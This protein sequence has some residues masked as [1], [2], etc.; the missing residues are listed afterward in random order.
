M[1][2]I[3]EKL[4][5]LLGTKAAIRQ[6]IRDK[7]VEVTD[8]DSFR[9]YADKIAS[10]EG[11]SLVVSRE[12]P[13][14]IFFDYD[15]SVAYSYTSEEALT[16]TSM[17]DQPQH[18]GL[19]R[20]G[21]NK[22]YEKMI[23]EVSE[24]GFCAVEPLYVTN[25]GH[26]RLFISIDALGRQ[27]YPLYI[28]A[29]VAGSVS[30]DWGDGS[31]E[32][33]F[34]DLTT[35][36]TYHFYA[37]E[38]D[39]IITV[40]AS[41][42]TITFGNGTSAYSSLSSNAYRNMLKKVYLGS[43]VVEIAN[44]TFCHC[45][46]LEAISVHN[47][48]VSIG[49]YAFFQCFNLALFP[50]A[51]SVS[52]IGDRAFQL[53]R[54][55]KTINIP[56]T[57]SSVP[58][59]LCERCYELDYLFIPNNITTV[60]SFA[61]VF[62]E[63]LSHI[64]W[65]L[66][67]TSIGDA[68]FALTAIE[69]FIPPESVNVLGILAFYGSL[70]KKVIV[71]Y[72]G[73]FSYGNACFGWCLKLGSVED[74][75]VSP[76]GGSASFFQCKNLQHVNNR[77]LS[78]SGTPYSLTSIVK[79]SYSDI[80]TQSNSSSYGTFNGCTKLKSI[81][82]YSSTRGACRSCSSLVNATFVRSVDVIAQDM[83]VD[84]SSLKYIDLTAVDKKVSLYAAPGK[85]GYPFL[86]CPGDFLVIVPDRLLETYK[87]DS[88]WAS[89]ADHIVGS[90]QPRV[91]TSL[92]ISADDVAAKQ[93]TTTIRYT[94]VTNGFDPRTGA[95]REGVIVTGTAT[96]EAF[97]VNGSF[98]STV[99]HTI[100]FSFLEVTASTT[101]T[102]AA[103]VPAMY[104]VVLN[105]QW[106]AS[107]VVANPDESLYEGVYESYSNY[108]VN[109]GLATMYIDIDGYETFKLYIRS[110]AESSYDYVMVGALDKAP[111]TS[112]NYANTSGVQ[113]SGTAISNYKLVVFSNI[114]GGPHRITI[115][116]RKDSSAHSGA[117]RGYVII[118]KNQ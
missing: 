2:S 93:T 5:Y 12:V 111:T 49:T 79:D 71:S 90:Y 92:E 60:K 24:C 35:I 78:S 68:A 81:D 18:D 38:G 77:G 15:G 74:M 114:D 64:R 98:D 36:D 100:T 65:S 108:N 25:D 47:K 10:I 6:A 117:D 75:S 8:E 26:T 76:S 102:Q 73:S 116:Y 82:I 55:L 106:R 17:P 95:E 97:A 69:E 52:F 110:H 72:R 86:D 19:T 32:E 115:V 118:P 99:E 21:W 14:V 67:L 41:E 34:P 51:N 105:N 84:C 107:E 29:T 112:S 44:Y 33:S 11:S 109:N 61:F 70:L 39:Y 57:I 62:C 9:D 20:Q 23:A 13:T 66:A 31:D 37:N 16:L 54:K 40:K 1:G 30:V 46:N 53:C 58:G 91:C 103:A 7:G 28:N 22:T 27:K 59:R 3:E 101:I 88:A 113:N 56:S 4:T 42:G 96:S 43:N 50:M 45:N 89:I 63:K 85:S 83:F 80:S 48:I 87:A 104:S 94:A